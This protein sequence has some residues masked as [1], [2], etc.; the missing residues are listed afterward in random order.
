[1]AGQVDVKWKR[2]A[3]QRQTLSDIPVFMT[4]STEMS[5]NGHAR[6]AQHA[7]RL[8]LWTCPPDTRLGVREV[9]EAVDRSP[10]WVYRAVSRKHAEHGCNPL[11]HSTFDG[12]LVFVA[13]A[14]RD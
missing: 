8:R 2:S 4:Y 9:A 6:C 10:A 14:V 13:S 12:Q 7:W 5:E 3:S 1:M 11:P